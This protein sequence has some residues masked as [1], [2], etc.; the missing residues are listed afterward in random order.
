MHTCTN[1]QSLTHTDLYTEIYVHINCLHKIIRRVDRLKI[2]IKWN[3][4]VKPAMFVYLTYII[5]ST[6]IMDD[7]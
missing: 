7:Q 1:S 3:N 5:S 6:N 4:Q 2:M